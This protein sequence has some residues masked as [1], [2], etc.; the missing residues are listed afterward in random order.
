MGVTVFAAIVGVICVAAA[1][2]F[3]WSRRSARRRAAAATPEALSQQYAQERH[4]QLAAIAR[5][6]GWT[7]AAFTHVLGGRIDVG[8][9]QDMVLLAWGG[10]AAVDHRRVSPQGVRVERW[11]YR[12]PD[13]AAQ[14][15]WFA[16]GRVR[17]V[18]G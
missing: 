15:V 7:E 1:A 13:G 10:P 3:L 11:V 16:D 9:T 14:Y 6:E 18:R 17:E 4:T 2:R 12:F 8:M 5:R